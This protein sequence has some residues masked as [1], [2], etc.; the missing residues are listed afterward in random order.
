MNKIAKIDKMDKITYSVIGGGWRAE[1]Y[2]RIAALLPNRFS[3]ACICVRNP[4]AAKRIS[5]R[6]DVKIINTV[7]EL[8]SIPCDFIVNCI[9]KADISELSLSLASDGYAILA[10]T[11]ACTSE[12]QA[13]K[14]LKAF[15]PD[16]KIQIAEQFHFKPMYQSIKKIIYGGIIGEANYI[17]ISVAHDYHAMSLIRFFLNSN[18]GKLIS[19]TEFSSPILHTNFRNG[20]VHNKAYQNSKHTIKTFDF[21]GKIAVY[22]FDAEQYFSPIRTDRLLIRGTRGEI[23]NDTVRYFNADDK[24]V[25]SKIVQHKSGAL[26]GLYNA[27]VTFENKVLYTY[28]FGDARL[29]DEETAKATALVKMKEYLE[30][31]TEFYSFKSG[32]KDCLYLNGTL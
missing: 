11:P 17:Y 21:D 15:K 27:D 10:E 13:E 4:E 5:E 23:E 8:K 12:E 16:Y 32:I 6:F 7:D 3:V 9:N 26:D 25:E 29:T 18:G 22:D 31:G 30:T 2:L 14:L 24:C 1:F 20:V 19:Q 28:P